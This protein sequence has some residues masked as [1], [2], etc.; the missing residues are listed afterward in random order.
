MVLTVREQAASQ[1]LAAV[2]AES[3]ERVVKVYGAGGFRELEAYQ[4]GLLV[5]PE[6]HVL[7][8]L[9]YVLD[10]DDVTVVLADGRRFDAEY[11]GADPLTELAV[12][13]L[14]P[15][16]APLPCFDFTDLAN[17][18]P[19]DPVLAVSN[20]YGIATGDEPVSVLQGV[21]T[22]VADLDARRGAA[23]A[24]YRGQVYIVD[25]ATNNPG[26][27]G[28]AVVDLQGR[29]LGVI[30]KELRS[31][32][33]GTWLN[34]ALPADRAAASVE[35]I[36][37]GQTADDAALLP[38]EQPLTTLNLGFRLVPDVLPRT[39]P[40]VDWVRPGGPADAAGLKPDDLVV[41]VQSSAVN[42]CRDIAG[43]LSELDQGA[44]VAVSLL[45]GEELI[46][47]ELTA[48]PPAEAQ[49]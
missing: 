20:L 9:S 42:S 47:V 11:L 2:I 7:T 6:G 39:P 32:V 26:A 28:G 45:R 3:Q 18:G 21:V 16:D 48:D 19:G 30:G 15:L 49:P 40:Y 23:R 31:R 35:A 36:L 10:T 22:A 8:L 24:R 5:S 25:A 44:V 43:R 1:E 34:Y 4:T 17:A 37:T 27:A 13:K 46:Q 38:P 33:T 41:F 14:P 12:L 29:L